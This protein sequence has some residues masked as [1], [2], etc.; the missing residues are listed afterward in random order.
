MYT[1]LCHELCHARKAWPGTLV[2]PGLL[3]G[4]VFV[5]NADIFEKE[6]GCFS[7]GEI[8]Y[9]FVCVDATFAQNATLVS[10]TKAE[11]YLLL[12]EKKANRRKKLVGLSG[13]FTSTFTLYCLYHCLA[14]SKIRRPRFFVVARIWN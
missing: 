3:S 11:Y 14:W 13:V 5:I 10:K 2:D 9:S 6:A 4:W 8:Q 1:T 12:R 7:S